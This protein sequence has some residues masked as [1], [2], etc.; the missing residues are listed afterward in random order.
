MV[1]GVGAEATVKVGIARSCV[2]RLL[3]DNSAQAKLTR[4]CLEGPEASYS[5]APRGGALLS[6]AQA[7]QH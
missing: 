3:K 2:G 1:S 5:L 7:G 4:Y 6:G